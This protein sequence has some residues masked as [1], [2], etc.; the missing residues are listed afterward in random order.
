MVALVPASRVRWEHR[1]ADLWGAI[2]W[3]YPLPYDQTIGGVTSLERL[4]ALASPAMQ[5]E[6]GLVR[7]LRLLLPLGESNVGDELDLWSDPRLVTTLSGA[8][9]IGSKH[10]EVMRQ[11]FLDEELAHQ[12]LA[13]IRRWHW[14]SEMAPEAWH[15]EVLAFDRL[16]AE[17]RRSRNEFGLLD[18][19]VEAA[20]LFMVGLAREIRH[21]DE[22]RFSQDSLRGWLGFIRGQVPRSML[23]AGTRAGRSLQIIDLRARVGVLTVLDPG[24][25]R[26]VHLKRGSNS[27]ISDASNAVAS[28]PH[29]SDPTRSHRAAILAPANH[30]RAAGIDA[31][32]DLYEQSQTTDRSNRIANSLGPIRHTLSNIPTRPRYFSGREQELAA[33]DDAFTRKNANTVVQVITGLGGIGKTCLAIEYAHTRAA[34]YDLRWWTNPHRITEDFSELA[35]ALG[36]ARADDDLDH[37]AEAARVFLRSNGRWLIIVDSVD[38]PGQFLD[39]VVHLGCGHVLIT[40][41]ATAWRDAVMPIEIAAPASDAAREILLARS[42]RPDDGHAT[43]LAHALGN[44]PLAL[45]QAAAYLEATHGNFADYL[46][47]F[48]RNGVGLV[49]DLTSDT[50]ARTWLPSYLAIQAESASAVALLEFLSFLNSDGFPIG[51][52][53][54]RPD[55]LPETLH[56]LAVWRPNLDKALAVLRRYSLIELENDLVRIHRLIQI[57]TR[58]ALDDERRL[59]L[60]AAVVEWICALFLYDPHEPRVST[61]PVVA[62]Q[63]LALS[64]RTECLI[65]AGAQLSRTL[66]DLSNFLLL[67][68]DTRT[69]LVAGRRAVN[70]AEM[71]MQTSPD[72]VQARQDLSVSLNRLSDVEVQVGNIAGARELLIRAFDISERLATVDPDSVRAQRDL[73]V[74]LNRLGD[75][76][77]QTGS[78]ARARDL[79]ARALHIGERLI[80]VDPDSTQAQQDLTVSLDKLGVIEAQLGNAAVARDFLTRALDIRE[81]QAAATPDSSRAQ[82]DLTVSLN[83]LGDV[84]FQAGNLA[85]ARDYYARAHDIG[86]RLAGADPDSAQARRDLAVSLDKLGTVEV[87]AVNLAVAREL[88]IRSHD[89][90]ERLAW[91][92]PDSA[93]ARRDLFIS[94]NRLG[95]VE[96]QAGNLGRARD[97]FARALAIAEHLATANSA[98]AQHDLSISLDN[99]GYIEV[100]FDKLA[101][102]REFLT[103]SLEIR[104]RL[105][106]AEP[107]SSQA[108]RGLSMSLNRYGD[109]EIQAGNLARARDLFARSLSIA[110]RLATTDSDQTQRD[111]SVALDNLGDIEVQSGNLAGAREL[112]TRSLD[113]REHLVTADPDSARAQRD[114]SVSL[115]KLSIVEFQAGNLAGARKLLSR[116]LDIAERQA[117]V[118]P[119]STQVQR[120]IAVSLNRLGDVE[121]Q[122]G[123]LA[124]ARALLTRAIEISEHQ[125]AADPDLVWAQRDLAVSLNRLGDVEFRTGNLASARDLF[126]RGHDIAVRLAAVDHDSAQAQRGLAVSLDKLGVVD[127]EAGNFAGARELLARSLD[128]LERLAIANPDSVR[129]QHDFYMSL[130]KLGVVEAK[131]GNLVRARELLA[132][133]LDIAEHQAAA[134]LESTRSL[135]DLAISFNNLGDVEAQADNLARARDLFTRALD[136]AERIAAADPDSAPAWRDLSVSLE[137]LGNFASQ[138]GD[139]TRARELLARALDIRKRLANTAPLSAISSDD[140]AHVLEA[141]Q[142]RDAGALEALYRRY[143]VPIK[144]YYRRRVASAQDVEDLVQETFIRSQRT[145]YTGRGSVRAFLL[146]IAYRVFLEYLRRRARKE[147]VHLQYN[148]ISVDTE[149]S[150]FDDPEYELG[151]K[152]EAR[153]LMKAMRLLPL[154]YQLV[155][156]LS[157]WEGLTQAEIATILSSADSTI[158]AATIGRWKSEALRALENTM[159]ELSNAEPQLDS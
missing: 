71:R 66:S 54:V 140:D 14:N 10:V 82:R 142:A 52:L 72:S 65:V 124:S 46:D 130:D 101:R 70:I 138:T 36:V 116:A 153:L 141:W 21:D 5:M 60:A 39:E 97:L 63:L 77:F 3:E 34:N 1:L 108:Q 127:A 112:L 106:I 27:N 80:A 107:D 11:R 68:G 92:D 61:V 24:L 89:I 31:Q 152:E 83:R 51:L 69:S 103:R 20:E 156:E 91:A 126:A 32:V 147:E 38:E 149:T 43:E 75:V 8:R 98:Q 76:E 105:A 125:A 134:G 151:Q 123:N 118:D 90:T 73:T 95:D 35:L 84:E 56:S 44:L 55:K 122:A 7:A 93:Q 155:L 59:A 146:G 115:D 113:I 13:V 104:E 85:S 57:V 64:E 88:F 49:T 143:G 144:S 136:I 114:L 41:R 40:S 62:D 129:A 117:V 109:F 150:I 119:Q 58:A 133:S 102:A 110:E 28:P 6:H 45:V 100:Q 74:S 94:L 22:D 4:L 23:T 37:A 15:L 50:V 33:I 67:R 157:H 96:L 79:L 2:P 111:L 42:G 128:I 159:M 120:N 135:R 30:L 16:L 78:H 158:P 86:E 18:T 26:F 139:H 9:S 53:S 12:A 99:L 81:R 154:R 137:K 145:T 19:E 48:R 132:R 25:R 121:F 29:Q 131:V 17:V 47:L 87:Q 148:D